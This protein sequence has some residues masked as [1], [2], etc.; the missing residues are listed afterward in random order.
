MAKRK[1]ILIL[2]PEHSVLVGGDYECDERG[3]YRLGAQ[4]E[5]VLRRVECSQYGGRCA[6]TLC[7]LHRYNRGGPLTWFPER[8]LAAPGSGPRK[9]AAPRPAPPRPAPPAPATATLF[10]EA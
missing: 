10:I 6:Q 5:F 3:Q 1:S 9:H 8:I 4:G 2:C 7:A